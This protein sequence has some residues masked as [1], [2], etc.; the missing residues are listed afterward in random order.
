LDHPVPGGYEYRD[1]LLQV[2]AGC[3][4]DHFA[5]SEEM[6][7][8]CNVA[9]SSQENSGSKTAL[10]P[11]LMKLLRNMG[12]LPNCTAYSNPFIGTDV[13]ISTLTE[14]EGYFY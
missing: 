4:A 5:K 9:E 13:K 6:K 8:G 11:M 12:K 14:R 2:G 3:K 7:T 10:L 1:V